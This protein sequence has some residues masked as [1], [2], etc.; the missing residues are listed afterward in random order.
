[1]GN[2]PNT[3]TPRQYFI[4]NKI[5]HDL[6]EYIDT[7]DWFK[8]DA[9]KVMVCLMRNQDPTTFITEKQKQLYDRM[10]L[11]INKYIYQYDL[12]KQ[13][14]HKALECLQ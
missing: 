13:D 7:G 10:K 14:I 2:D 5:R 4:Y 1:M 8:D 12:D 9:S 11:I 3:L 6:N